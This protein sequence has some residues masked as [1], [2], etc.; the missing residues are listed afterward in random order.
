[1]HF[2]LVGRVMAAAGVLPLSTAEVERVFSQL[3]LIKTD[4]R[5]SLKTKRLEQLLNIKLSCTDDLFS[6]L[7]PTV[8]TTFFRMKSRRLVT[9]TKNMF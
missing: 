8:V 1:M 5:C 2:P 9:L 3:K 6:K 4:H 7:M